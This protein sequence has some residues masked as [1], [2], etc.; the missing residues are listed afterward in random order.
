MSVATARQTRLGAGVSG[1]GLVMA[2]A[3]VIALVIGLG[4]GGADT[5]GRSILYGAMPWANLSFGC[6]GMMLLFHVTRGRWGNPVLRIFE[7]GSSPVMMAIWF[8]TFMAVAYLFGGDVYSQWWNGP[9][10]ENVARK[11]HFLNPVTFTVMMVIYFGAMAGIGQLLKGWTRKEEETGDKAFSDKRNNL[12]APGIVLFVLIMTFLMTH[13]VMSIDAHWF[14][15]IFG[16]WFV[17]GGALA[18]VALATFMA[19]TQKDKAPFY[20]KIDELMKR[21]FGNLMLMFTMIWAYFSFSQFLI[22]WSG[23]LPEFIPFYLK[24]LIGNFSTVGAMLTIGGFL[25]PFLLLLS[26]RLKR[27]PWMLAFTAMWILV[28][29]FIDM[30]WIISPYFRDYAVPPMADVGALLL[31]GGVWFLVFGASVV[32]NTKRLVTTAHPYMHKEAV[33]H[34]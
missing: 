33:D 8:V 29:R 23:N 20:G 25:I 12:A 10:D 14:S 26:P 32:S 5:M 31:F 6:F 9:I 21:D 19:V 7:A 27:T 11:S 30:H 4:T 34:V 15:T 16:V 28:L 3:G 2:I 22:I 18:A 1:L 24:R 17:V 13:V